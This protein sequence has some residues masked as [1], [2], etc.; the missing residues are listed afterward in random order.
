MKTKSKILLAVAAV[1][2]A[3]LLTCPDKS[4]HLEVVT[5]TLTQAL[6]ETVDEHIGKG[7]LAS[8]IS[9]AISSFASKSIVTGYLENNFSVTD[10][11]IFSIGKVY[12]NG[13]THQVSFGIAKH[14]FT[15]GTDK[16][17]D[18]INGT[19]DNFI[20]NL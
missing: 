19:V 18:G 15:I 8:S 6:N 12:L 20:N 11:Y 9:G 13:K 5:D 17:K 14:V 3:L 2:L 7:Q 4:Q 10:Y 1:I 16:V